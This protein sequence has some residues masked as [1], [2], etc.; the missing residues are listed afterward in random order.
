M[1][2]EYTGGSFRQIKKKAVQFK[3]GRL[4]ANYRDL[5]GISL[6]AGQLCLKSPGSNPSALTAASGSRP[7]ASTLSFGAII[8]PIVALA[9]SGSCS[10]TKKT[11]RT[12]G[13]PPDGSVVTSTTWP[14]AISQYT[15]NCTAAS[16]TQPD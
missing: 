12:G 10:A 4:L 6:D 16:A 8:A 9:F 5:L 3:C 15:T 1:T 14:S 2:T 7:H 13:P 11:E